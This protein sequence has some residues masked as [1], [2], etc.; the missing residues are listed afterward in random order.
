MTSLLS[1]LLVA[2]A[3]LTLLPG[4]P[5]MAFDAGCASTPE[6]AIRL[7]RFPGTEQRHLQDTGYRVKSM[8]Y[9]PVL[10]QQWA[11]IAS[12][13]HPERP[14][15]AIHMDSPLPQR[16]GSSAPGQSVTYGQKDA[17]V[18]AGDIVQA[19]QQQPNLRIEIAGRAVESGTM[20]SPVRVR[21]LRSGFEA[22]QP[23]TLSGIVRGPGNVE[24]TQ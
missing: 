9:D 6:L 21:V 23:L 10:D 5:L 11:V 16:S 20:G 15:F 12:C 22:G 1:T 7:A 14:T 17:L 24:I 19:W 8:R 4:V 3:C 13:G 18:H 2:L